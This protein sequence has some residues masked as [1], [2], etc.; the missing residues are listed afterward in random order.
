MPQF[1]DAHEI[2]RRVLGA[3]R[4]LRGIYLLLMNSLSSVQALGIAPVRKVFFRQVYFTGIEAMAKVALIGTLI[5]IV[6]ITQVSNLVGANAVL[7]GKILIWIVVRELGPLFA[8]II[9]IARSCTA[10]TAE[11]GSMSVNKEVKYL[12]VMGVD[13][14]SYLIMPR[15]LGLTV[16]V[17]ILTFYFQVFAIL[18]GLVL[19]SLVVYIPFLQQLRNIF[20]ELSLYEIGISLLKS[21]MFGF[22]ISGASCYY[23]LRVRASITEV[24]Q[25]TTVA[26]M[27]SLFMVLVLNGIITVTT[28]V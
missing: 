28:F 21:A 4:N 1:L 8:A 6:I 10:V 12:R 25:A 19:S 5:G 20:S 13:P 18:A 27:Q 26:V 22:V 11:L 3:F 9:I 7:I 15:V 2:G 23:G 14:M 24:P 17:F 16:S